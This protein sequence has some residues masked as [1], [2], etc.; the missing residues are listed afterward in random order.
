MAII[1]V[2]LVEDTKYVI[3][4]GNRKISILIYLKRQVSIMFFW[5]N[6]HHLE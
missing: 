3:E 4:I 2:T 1:P 6:S 5:Q